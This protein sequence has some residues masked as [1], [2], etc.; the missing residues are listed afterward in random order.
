[1]WMMPL[2]LH[3]NQKS[4]YDM[5]MSVITSYHMMTK[6]V[7]SKRSIITL[8]NFESACVIRFGTCRIFQIYIQCKCLCDDMT[9]SFYVEILN[10]IYDLFYS[11]NA[12]AKSS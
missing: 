6:A 12:I 9:M 1:M 4:D 8:L 5:M 11:V 3:V 7:F 10:K 2:H